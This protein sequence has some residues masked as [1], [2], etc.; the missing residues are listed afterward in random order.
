MA[1]ALNRENYFLHRIHSLTGIVPVGYY[2]VQHLTL[3][4]FSVAGPKAFDDLIGFFEAMPKHLLLGLEIFAI[5]LPLLFHSIYGLFIS[6]RAKQ[7]FIGTKYGWNENRMFFLQRWTGIYLFFA[8]IIHVSMTTIRKY[9]TGDAEVIKYAAWQEK[10][11]SAYGLWMVF[12][13]MLVLT[14]SY[15]L[16]YGIW[17]FCIRWGITVSDRAQVRIQKFSLGAFVLLTLL[18][19]G[20]LAG[21]F[22][23][24]PEAKGA[25]A[26]QASIVR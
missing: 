5:W 3:N 10:L 16:A 26:V 21:F 9:V 6:A 2:M 14:A 4:T 13:I 15:H 25:E 11:S 19:W 24:K 8:L 22:L 17:N 7:N 12:Y 20:A 1:L 23:H 18:G